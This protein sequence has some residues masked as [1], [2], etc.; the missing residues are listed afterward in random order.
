MNRKTIFTTVLFSLIFS[1]VV[2]AAQYNLYVSVYKYGTSQKI[3]ANITVFNSTNSW[4]CV[5]CNNYPWTLS[6]ASGTY[7][8]NTESTGYQTDTRSLT[9][10]SRDKAV[11]VYLK[12]GQP[13]DKPPQWSNLK[14][15]PDPAYYAPNQ[16][17]TFSIVWTD[18][19]GISKVLLEFNGA[20][21]TVSKTNGEY[22][23][24]FS[25]LAAGNYNYRWFAN[26]TN[27]QWNSTSLQTYKINKAT[28][29]LTLTATPGWNVNVGTQTSVYC[30]ANTNQV[31]LNLIRNGVS[32]GNP[33]VATLGIGNYNYI[34][35]STETQNYTT[36]STSNTLTVSS[37]VTLPDLTLS[38]SDI[39]FNPSNPSEGES[40]LIDVIIHNTGDASASDVYYEIID[41]TLSQTLTTGTVNSIAASSSQT[42]S[43]NWNNVIAGTHT[44]KVVVDPANSITEKNETNNEASKDIFVSSNNPP[45]CS[46]FIANPL[47]PTVYAPGASYYFEATCTDDKGIT[48][49]SFE[50]D[51]KNYTAIKAGN[52]YYLNFTDLAAGVYPNKWFATDTNNVQATFPQSDYVINK[53]VTNTR[54]FFNGTES[55]RVY[56]V[57]DIAN[58]TAMLDSLPGKIL[59][60]AKDG[61]YVASG[62]SP[63]ERLIYLTTPGSSTYTASFAGDQNY[64]S[65]S[66]THQ[67][68]VLTSPDTEAPKYWN[69][70]TNPTSPTTYVPSKTYE[71]LCGWTDNVGVANV[72]LEFNGVNYTAT[73]LNGDWR[74]DR[75]DLA[76]NNYN[77]RWFATDASGNWN[78]TTMQT[79]LVDKAPT[80]LR[81][82]LNGI[83]SN[84]NYNLFDIANFTAVLDNLPGKTVSIISDVPGFGLRTGTSPF[85]TTIQLLFKGNFNVTGYFTG[86]QNYSASSQTYF[87]NVDG[88]DITPPVV[89]IIAPQNTTYTIP[90]FPSGFYWSI[91]EAFSWAAYSLDGNA[92]V[93]ITGNVTPPPSEAL[94]IGAH[95]LVIYA[96]DIAGNLGYDEVYYTVIV[97][98][99]TPP[100]VIILSPENI[101][102]SNNIIDL[103][104]IVDEPITWSGYSLDG[105]ANITSGNT[106]LS[107]LTSGSHN[108]VVYATDLAGNT[109]FDEVGFAINCLSRLI[110]SFVDSVYYLDSNTNI[111]G[112]STITCSL[113]N[114]TNVTIS[115]IDVSDIYLSKIDNSTV[116]NATVNN[117]KISGSIFTDQSCKDSTIDPSDVQRS[118]TTGSTITDSHVWDSNATY[119]NITLSTLD[120]CDVTNSTLYNVT[121]RNSKIFLSNVS[122]SSIINSDIRNSTIENSNVHDSVVEDAIIRDNVLIEGCITY[123][124]VKH[125]APPSINLNDIYNPVIPPAPPSGGSGGSS[126]GFN[127]WFTLTVPSSF[128]IEAGETKSFNVIVTNM[129]RLL[130][131]VVLKLEGVPSVWYTIN[132][133]SQ[134]IDGETS[135]TYVITITIPK[136]TKPS[137]SILTFTATGGGLDAVAKMNLVI[138]EKGIAIP[139]LIPPT[140]TI[141]LLANPFVATGVIVLIT[142]IILVYIYY[143]RKDLWDDMVLYLR[144]VYSRMKDEL[145]D[146]KDKI[147]M[148]FDK[149]KIKVQKFF[150]RYEIEVIEEYEKAP[151]V[152]QTE[153]EAKEHPDADDTVKFTVEYEEK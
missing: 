41:T 71:F 129:K 13:S 2:L 59:T 134:D 33:D 40:V 109:G 74:V 126:L 88:S 28:P 122:N 125:C 81:L 17:Y 34:C 108:I 92:N 48:A 150:G 70:R 69:C 106:T 64:T 117:C 45:V 107:G 56:Y 101:T 143:Y 14:A 43:Y 93:T 24:T 99:T 96:T 140:G 65:S 147:K 46:N 119:S 49:V 16:D 23:R 84:R 54:L 121:C 72:F 44:V 146:L 128:T 139:P 145:Y 86:N 82:F 91:N 26:D 94:T 114:K 90:S 118:N 113:I 38:S 116:K 15:L 55:D 148:N 12:T 75:I 19:I 42:V 53:A 29:V 21:Y 66:A 5:N 123:N 60:I 152:K 25:D 142:A 79:Y 8:V 95:H 138:K 144:Q 111:F 100:T 127:N 135:V 4:N 32:K 10:Y 104:F 52:I 3:P 98:D 136:E 36:T 68:T 80:T 105:Q 18:D 89:N 37:V 6:L 133:I 78:Q 87:I 141:I 85:Q 61:G 132:P 151:E 137:T 31:S 58:I 9:I 73:R 130:P 149:M 112:T 97:Q 50:F 115:N 103:I 153:I 7:T 131:G 76:A 67:L 77:Y 57:N 39:T 83:E 35:A 120:F 47:S 110:D 124:G 1:S 11:N 22:T 62:P 27:N 20:N 30:S 102:Y 63:V 51:N